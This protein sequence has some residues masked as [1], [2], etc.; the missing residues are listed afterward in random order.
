MI[1]LHLVRHGHTIWSESGG[2]AGRT[3]IELSETGRA[4]VESLAKTFHHEAVAMQWVCSP[5]KRTRETAEIIRT[6]LESKNACP[7]PELEFDKRLVELDFGDWEGQTWDEVHQNTPDLLSNW[8]EDWVNRSPPNGETFSEQCKRCQSWLNDW[9][10]SVQD[11]PKAAA[12]VISHGGSIRAL[13]CLCMDWDFSD[14]MTFNVDPAS[15]CW[16]QCENPESPWQ[17]KAI[18]SQRF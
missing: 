12:T 10:S 13:I 17:I 4:S 18:N 15:Q 9:L 11:E 2:V 16:L 7:L 6:L 14:A 5:M 1:N 8:G 3:D